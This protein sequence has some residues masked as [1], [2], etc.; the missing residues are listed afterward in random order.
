MAIHDPRNAVERG[1]LD[2]VVLEHGQLPL[3]SESE[4]APSPGGPALCAVWVHRSAGHPRGARGE[5][6]GGHIARTG[7]ELRQLEGRG[8]PGVEGPRPRRVG[9]VRRAALALRVRQLLLSARA[10]RAATRRAA[11]RARSAGSAA[12]ISSRSRTSASMAELNELLAAATAATTTGVASRTGGSRVGEHFA[13][14][15]E[16]LRPLPAERVRRRGGRLASGRPQEPGVGARRVSTRSRPATSAGA[17]M[18][19]SAPRPSR[20]STAPTVVASPCPGPQRRR[21]AG[22]GPLPRG[23]APQARGA[24]RRPRR[25]PGP[26]PPARSAPTHERFWAEARRRLGDRDGTRALIEVL[27]A[28]RQ[29]PRRRGHRRHATRA[30]DAGLRRPGGRGDRS[31]QARRDSRPRAGRPD[32]RRLARFDRPPPT[33]ADYD[34]LLEAQ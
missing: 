10:S 25:W 24:A 8:R 6:A 19:A 1:W 23:A 4:E 18:S 12:A 26:A 20:C 22:A 31:P 14:E 7:T 33:L 32:R 15:A 28:H 13:L 9:P 2:E 16:A 5:V 11:S 3:W 30:L 17:S 34:D 21:G 27:L 29:P